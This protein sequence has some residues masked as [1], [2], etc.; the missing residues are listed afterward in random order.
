MV[1]ESNCHKL[2]FGLLTMK[3]NSSSERVHA[4][5]RSNMGSGKNASQKLHAGSWWP[6]DGLRLKAV[7]GLSV[8]WPMGVSLWVYSTFSLRYRRTTIDRIT[9]FRTDKRSGWEKPPRSTSYSKF[10]WSPSNKKADKITLC[11]NRTGFKRCT[12]LRGSHMFETNH[13]SDQGGDNKA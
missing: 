10:C 7:F 5:Q 3:L 11:T 1:K 12:S 13:E 6:R 4:I 9:A 8:S 2:L